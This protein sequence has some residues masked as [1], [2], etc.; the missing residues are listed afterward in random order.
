MKATYRIDGMT[1]QGCARS[2]TRAIE[3]A[4]P[5]LKASVD[6]VHGTA[7]VEGEGDEAAIRRAVETAGFVFKGQAAPAGS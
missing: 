1:C 3:R 6:H 4:V 7:A 5:T 2:V